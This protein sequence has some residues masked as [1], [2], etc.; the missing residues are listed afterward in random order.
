VN[1]MGPYGR[2]RESR[3]KANRKSHKRTDDELEGS[4][5]ELQPPMNKVLNSGAL[6][7]YALSVIPVTI[8][9]DL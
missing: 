6:V 5:N 8:A 9:F 2:H 3:A 4:R 7:A 1:A